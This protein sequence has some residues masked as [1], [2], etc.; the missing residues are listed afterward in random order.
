MI[1]KG[2]HFLAFVLFVPPIVFAKFDKPR[3]IVF[4]FNCVSVFLIFIEI[5]R[6]GEGIFP[7]RMTTWFKQ[8]CNGRER[9]AETMILTH[10]YLLMGCGFPLTASYI[11]LSGGVFPNEWVIWSLA[12]VIVLGVGD[13]AA[14][15]LGKWYGRTKWRELSSKT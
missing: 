2:F 9:M 11:L 12:G 1:R 5:I 13:S 3:M 7:Q 8:F 10:I 15:I 6:W 14:A 4:A